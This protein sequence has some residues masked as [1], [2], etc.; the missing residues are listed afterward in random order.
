MH[1]KKILNCTILLLS[2]N[3]LHSQDRNPI[4]IKSPE[5]HSFEKAGNVPINL[6][7]GSVDLKI[8]ICD[9]QAKSLNIPVVL[10]YD[11]SGFVPHKKTDLAGTNWSLIVGGKISRNIN[12]L[13]DEYEGNPTSLV[14]GSLYGLDIHGYLKGVRLKPF[15]KEQ[16]YDL[17]SGVGTATV[18]TWEL[19]SGINGYEG[20]P[21][22][23]S[24][25]ILGLRGK[26]MIGN[27]GVVKVKSND[28]NLK[29][30]ISGLKT[31]GGNGYCL[32]LD[33]EIILTDGNG[34]K[35]FFGGDFSK[36]EVSY[37]RT[38]SGLSKDGFYGFPT[39]N[40]FNISKIIMANSEVITFDYYKGTLDSSFCQMMTSSTNL[41][42]NAKILSL[43]SYYQEGTRIDEF[44]N[45]PGGVSGC[46]TSSS[47]GPA[48]GTSYTLLKRSMLEKITY[49]NINISI[50]YKS[51]GYPIKHAEDSNLYFN[52]FVI[53]NIE[54]KDGSILVKKHVFEYQDLGG[55]NKRPFLTGLQETTAGKKHSF[56]Y[57]KTDNLP[58]YYTTG[59]D[60]WGFWNG[61][62][63]N[64]Q[65]AP[66]D[67]YNSAT[68]DYTL[69]NTSRDANYLYGSSA[70]LSKIIYP[71]KGF[72]VF[73]YEPHLYSKRIE[74]NSG[75]LFL[76]VL[77]DAQGICGG[78]RIQK[79]TDYSSQGV[80]SNIK[81]Y[82]YNTDIS[83]TVSSGILSNWPRYVY[84]FEF[85]APG[86]I[87]KL[88]LKSSS[89]VQQNTLD[90]YNVGYSKVYEINSSNGYIEHSFYN[91]SDKPDIS[92]PY[93]NNLRNWT[94][95]N[96][97][98]ITPLNLYK[99]FKNLYG[100]DYSSIRGLKSKEKF[101]SQ[102][103][104]AKKTI[105][106]LY[107]DFVDYNPNSSKDNN[108]YV[109]INHLSGIWV[110][111]Y[112]KYFNSFELKSKIVTEKFNGQDIITQSDFLYNSPNHLQLSSESNTGSNN[113]IQQ[114]KY[115]YPNDYSFPPLSTI[116]AAN[117]IH[118]MAAL[119]SN[120]V[121]NVPVE[122]SQSIIKGG[123]EYVTGGK[124]NYFENLNVEKVFELETNEPINANTFSLSTILPTGFIYDSRYK[125]SLSFPKY[126]TKGNI[127]EIKPT[128]GI[129]ESYIWGY[130]N[131]Y[132]IA[133]VVNATYQEITNALGTAVLTQ[134]NNGYKQVIVSPGPPQIIYNNIPLT[135][136]EIRTM[137]LP[138]QT[139]LSN[140]QVT[141]FTYK[142][143]V[144]MTSTTD[145]KGITTYYEYDSFN[146]LYLVKDNESK[147]LSETNYNYKN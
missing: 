83:N 78:T 137:L 141:I 31:Y 132:P 71:T 19:S 62:D 30:D 32:P 74:R 52:E 44:R 16:V 93:T 4:S 64:T 139:S 2:V 50:N 96:T 51:Q 110:Q 94:N 147:I 98:T 35:Y 54:L 36:Y 80:V 100:L 117:E 55:V 57:S 129:T 14:P 119:V 97:T 140:A 33:S 20:E 3:L 72:T 106:Y 122:I 47:S 9:I 60:H 109:S 56:E 130:N 112:K 77:V 75:S 1:L 128:N 89:N 38:T 10:S 63:T 127:L 43:D 123:V 115:K 18:S 39:I 53:D 70:L 23:F 69:N 48:T 61:K 101:V 49:N 90:S 144:G 113:V 111:G 6:F 104:I 68:G 86:S 13:P 65:Y 134:L 29:V 24:F 116:P 133:K 73:E 105:D 87:Q 126:D 5:T 103:G 84:Y 138:L 27:D 81:E 99:N 15:S 46:Y 76:P 22:L 40:S 41:L 108:N 114:T 12:G 59:I 85:T 7:A 11:S 120:N 82:K 121:V 42:Q 142:P 25:S 26:F 88:F 124:L 136:L 66:F 45:C 58:A 21:D 102:D 91:Y 17:N 28:P 135:D 79:Q 131:Q 145:Q 146:R 143:L 37:S 125:E 67:T 92:L 107:N 8:P 95:D 34:N 118:D